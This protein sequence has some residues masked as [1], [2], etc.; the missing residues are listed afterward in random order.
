MD[1]TS[2]SIY[3]KLKDE[4]NGLKIGILVN[5]VGMMPDFGRNFESLSENEIHDLINCN[6]MSMARMCHIIIPQMVERKK[7]VVINIGSLSSAML[8]PCLT[9]YGAT[10]V[11]LQRNEFIKVTFL[12]FG[13]I[14]QGICGQILFGCSGRNE[15]SR[16]NSANSSSWIRSDQFGE[17]EREIFLPLTQ[18]RDCGHLHFTITWPGASNWWLLAP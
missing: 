1:F 5:N 14:V 11:T 13:L 8:T 7:G 2:Q 3:G 18:S 4:L 6:V 10:K 9:T 16:S 15:A 17:Q 12:I